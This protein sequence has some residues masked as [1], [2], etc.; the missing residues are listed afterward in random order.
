M[1]RSSYE[2]GR[3]LFIVRSEP[4]RFEPIELMTAFDVS[5]NLLLQLSRLPPVVTISRVSEGNH[6]LAVTLASD[7]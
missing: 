4:K 7:H 3:G 2:E 1:T 5:F 6:S